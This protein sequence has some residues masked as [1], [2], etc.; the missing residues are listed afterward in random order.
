M[1]LTNRFDPSTALA[2]ILSCDPE[3]IITRTPPDLPQ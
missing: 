3:N 2:A 1:D